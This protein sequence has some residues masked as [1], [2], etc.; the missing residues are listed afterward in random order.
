MALNFTDDQLKE[1]S[2]QVLQGPD[3]IKQAED[4]VAKVQQ[5][6]Q[7][8]LDLDIQNKVFTDDMLN[9]I[10]QFHKELKELS[11]TVKTLYNEANIELAAK[12][13]PSNPHFPQP[14][15]L[16]FYPKVLDSNA[17]LPTS[18]T[19]DLIEPEQLDEIQRLYN[20]LVNGF[21]DG[22]GYGASDGVVSSGIIPLDDEPIGFNV[23]DRI[24]VLASGGATGA[25][26]GIITAIDTITYPPPPVGPT[27][28]DTYAIQYTAEFQTGTL[29]IGSA[30]TNYH[31]GFTNTQREAATSNLY[32]IY[33]QTQI[34]AEIAKWETDFLDKLLGILNANDGA[35]D[36][37]EIDAEKSNISNSK[38]IV[39]NW[40]AKPNTGMGVG[41]FGDSSIVPLFNETNARQT[42]IPD[43][44]N[45]INDSLGSLTQDLGAGKGKFSGNGRYF[46]Y[47]THLN[48]RIHA[49]D[50]SLRNHYGQDPLIDFS[51]QQKDNILAEIE[52]TKNI[53][54]IK[55]LKSN[56]VG[57]DILEM[58]DISDL[59]VGESVK[60]MDNAK[61]VLNYT[62]V[63]LI[64]EERKIQLDGQTPTNYSL[65]QQA[66]IVK[67]L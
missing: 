54:Q 35:T 19:S 61:P 26:Y 23:G 47:F 2:G 37:S 59:Q 43:R 41:R 7:D 21:S 4:T 45:E 10:D 58:V 46:D 16:F 20:L 18:T 57:S 51:I 22:S 6:K 55:L 38:A 14:D 1:L 25:S 62:I 39:D 50:G 5:I 33:L 11:G 52:R 49:N 67:V 15:W 32:Q 63:S 28:P 12:L 13:D 3:V 29:G 9:I 56:P 27:P 64:P 31:P 60:L 34:D 8:F 53:L 65:T 17:G 30:F 66:R 36:K 24:L 44:I 48:S 42:R 40:Q